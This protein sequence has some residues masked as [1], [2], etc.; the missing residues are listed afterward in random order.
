MHQEGEGKI[1]MKQPGETKG[2][3]I[4]KMLLAALP[5]AAV[6]GILLAVSLAGGDKEPKDQGTAD[7]G[8]EMLASGDS[9]AGKVVPEDLETGETMLE[10]N[11]WS[12]IPDGS[13]SGESVSREDMLVNYMS[14][15]ELQVLLPLT[16]LQEG[17]LEGQFQEIPEEAGDQISNM[18]AEMEL[19]YLENPPADM[20]S[21]K[22]RDWGRYTSQ[23]AREGLPPGQGAFYDRLDALCRRYLDNGALD[24]VEYKKFG[25]FTT[26]AVMYSDLGLEMEEAYDILW[27]FKYNNPQY[28]FL[29]G[30]GLK[31]SEALYPYLYDF[32]VSGEERVKITNELFDKLDGWIGSVNDDEVTNW[33]RELAANHLLCDRIVY[34]AEY[35]GDYR[36]DQSLYSA[37]MMESTV[38]AGY[39]QAFCAMMNASGVETVVAL[40][41]V[42]AWNVVCLDDGGYYAVDVTWNDNEDEDGE[43]GH[44][45]L[46][47]GE[48]SLKSLDSEK[49]HTYTDVYTTWIPGISQDD[50][51]PTQYDR[52]GE[53]PD[54]SVTLPGTPENLHVVSDEDGILGVMWNAVDHASGYTVE[55][56]NSDGTKLLTSASFQNPYMTVRYGTRDLLAIRVR[57]EAVLD[58][59]EYVSDWSEFLLADTSAVQEPESSESGQE[60]L[61]AP[62]N[63][64]VTDVGTSYASFAWDRVEGA[65]QYQVVLFR[66]EEHS[67]TWV[68]SNVTDPAIKYVK[69]QPDT[70]YHYG[71]RAMKTVDGEDIYSDWGYFSLT[72]TAETSQ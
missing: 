36:I 35:M 61:H 54:E 47:V 10:G 25:C 44:R 5:F 53:D 26:D 67:Q 18:V 6:L 23:L 56:Y 14:V 50:Y 9:V 30:W 51:V 69:L 34:N 31:T 13:K 11:A 7:R 64:A 39:A 63:F 24:G 16:V 45:F 48:V 3:Q 65:A 28:Y 57:A 60:D 66:D 62:G 32:A 46:N 12:L 22:A 52:T 21:V 41:P 55:I 49:E 68:S 70:R 58:G 2:K 8:T 43:P 1:T 29:E 40:S 59:E 17:Y 33:Q 4:V 20:P 42:H 71:V 27:W 19:A 72:T 15:E 38:C 37:V